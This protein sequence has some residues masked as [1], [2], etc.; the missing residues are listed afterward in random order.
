MPG[1]KNARR[2]L[3]GSESGDLVVRSHDVAGNGPPVNFRGAVVNAEGTNVLVCA[4]Y[5]GLVSDASAA[6]DLHGTVDN[7]ADGF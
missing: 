5:D 3:R 4:H 1:E 6:E 2:S 7:A